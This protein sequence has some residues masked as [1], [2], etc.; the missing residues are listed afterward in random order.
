M[1]TSISVE[2]SRAIPVDVQHGF[3][4]TLPI[5]LSTIFCRRYALLPPIKE[6]RGQ[7]G[8]WGHVGQVRTVVTSDGGTMR[9]VLTEVDRPHSF[10]YQLSDI[11]GPMRPLVDTIDGRWEFT[12]KGTGTLITWRWTLHPRGVGALLMPLI[13]RMWLGYAKQSLEQLSDLLL[14]AESTDSPLQGSS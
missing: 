3:D 12:S 1:A 13:L 4:G 14:A 9:E 10:S 2:Q 6:V 11:T 8:T 7:I 5:P